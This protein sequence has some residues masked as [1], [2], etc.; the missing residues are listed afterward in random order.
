MAAISGVNLAMLP[1][2]ETEF[3]AYLETTGDILACWMGDNPRDFQYEPQPPAPFLKKYLKK[4]V[5]YDQ[6]RVYLGH[7]KDVLKPRIESRPQTIDG[8]RVLIPHINFYA[9]PVLWYSR[10]VLSREKVL[11]R[12]NV[13]MYTSY[14]KGNTLVRKSPE[15]IAWGRKVLAWLRRR[16]TDEVPIYRCNYS[17][18]ATAKAADAAR[19]GRIKVT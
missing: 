16:A 1:E 13:H 6:V 14:F 3:F 7:E 10:G 9:T 12:T 15:F 8:K 17:L 4:I 11:D 2:E 18:Q 19:Q 5:W